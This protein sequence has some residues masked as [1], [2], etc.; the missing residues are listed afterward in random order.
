VD[1]TGNNL[2]VPQYTSRKRICGTFIK[3]SITQPFKKVKLVAGST[4]TTLKAVLWTTLG[5][6]Q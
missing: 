6:V 4:D 2:D 5:W 1:V 3:S